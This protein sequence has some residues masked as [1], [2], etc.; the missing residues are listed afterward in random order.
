ML[1][2]TLRQMSDSRKALVGWSLF[3]AGLLA[4]IIGVWFNH[5]ANF[6]QIE[7]V[8]FATA[9]AEVLETG[10]TVTFER[11]SRTV[12][13][14]PIIDQSL[15]L[16][17]VDLT[18]DVSPFGWVPRECLVGALGEMCLPWSTLGHL[19]AVAGSQLMFVGLMIALVLGR[20]MTWALATFAAFIAMFELVLLLGTVSS[21]WLN[22]A[23]GPLN[24]TEQNEAFTIWGPLVLGNDVGVS[25]G[26]IKDVISINYNLG[27]LTAV[28]LFAWKIQ[29]WGQP[30]P[31]P[32]PVEAPT[33]PY[34]RPL[35]KGAQVRSRVSEVR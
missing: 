22:L 1:Q 17:T 2:R 10:D 14:T 9:G 8:T 33:S 12:A 32:A 20:R 19:V 5:Y 11:Q 29:E 27:V 13:A 34:G 35:V 4:L 31:E 3:V 21:E 24:W 7:T 25:W 23:Q 6:P 26:A 18:V 28:V 15:A 16:N 30:L